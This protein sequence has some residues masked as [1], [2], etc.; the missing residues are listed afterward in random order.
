MLAVETSID[1]GYILW[2]FYDCL[3]D[4]PP[5]QRMLGTFNQHL[6]VI[7]S[8]NYWHQSKPT[9]LQCQIL[10]LPNAVGLDLNMGIYYK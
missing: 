10:S 3:Y 9:S 5:G 7:L 8:N 2:I 1:V 4:A 6:P